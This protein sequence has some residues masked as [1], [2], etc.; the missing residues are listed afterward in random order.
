YSINSYYAYRANG[1]FQNA[2]EVAAG[3]HLDGV[4]PKPGDIRYIDK[5]GDNIINAND[6]FVLGNPF[7]R[8]SFGL[9][10]NFNFKGLDFSMFWQGVGQRSV[11]L[12]GESVEAFHNNNEGPVFDFHMD[13]WTPTNPDATYPRLTVGAESTN[14]AA[15]SNFWIQNGAYVRLKNIQLGYTIP[16]SLTK[17]VGVNRLRVYLSGENLLTLSKMVG[18]W[19]PETTSTSGG[20][21]YP[22]A[23]VTSIGLNLTL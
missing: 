18:G 1:F 12:R 17:K 16:A 15:K 8:Y 14:N 21:I 11:W 19:D 20:R 10:Y 5:D 23:T 9:N 22:V 6:R 2:A 3:P 4:T 13:R 7:P